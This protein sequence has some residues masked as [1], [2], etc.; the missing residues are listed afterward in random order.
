M[1]AA[2]AGDTISVAAGTYEESLV[3]TKS[4]D[5]VGA[6]SKTTI[7]H[8]DFLVVDAASSDLV[9]S[10]FTIEFQELG[11]YVD[12]EL[13]GSD[14]VFQGTGD[15]SSNGGG[16]FATT[17][18]VDL[19][20]CVFK[21][22]D[23][24]AAYGGLFY[25]YASTVT[26]AN[27]T[28]EGGISQSGGAMYVSTSDVSIS[29]SRFSD[30]E[31]REVDDVPRGAA[32]RQYLGT[33]SLTDVDFT[34]NVVEGGYGAGIAMHGGSAVV[35]RGSFSDGTVTD[36]YGSAIAVFEG[37]LTMIDTVVSGNQEL[38]GLATEDADGALFFFGSTPPTFALDGVT[39]DANYAD[40][41]GSAI[42]VSTGTGTI[43]GCVFTN[44]VSAD[45]GGAIYATGPDPILDRR[46][47][48][49]GK[50]REER[51]CD[52][53]P[54]RSFVEGRRHRDGRRLRV[55]G[56]RGRR[57]RRRHLRA[58]RRHARSPG[59]HVRR[60]RGREGR[61]RGLRVGRRRRR[62]GAQSRGPQR[63]RRGRRV[64][65][66]RQIATFVASSNRFCMNLA[67][68]TTTSD[69][70]AASPLRRRRG[71]HAP[72]V[73]QHLRPQLRRRER[74]RFRAPR[75]R[76]RRGREQHVRERRSEGRR[77]VGLAAF[78]HDCERSPRS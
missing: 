24:G 9:L 25:A 71:R 73:E 20:G 52:P 37:D 60:Q 26:I 28:F 17:A 50:H 18:V 76:G 33:V 68:N 64:S 19:D 42:R 3:V 43:A 7:L 53:L 6:G 78:G 41:D 31:A 30:N 58:R 65:A 66:A 44:N 75:R 32:V 14:L 59:Q 48:L 74:R 38:Y 29:S 36:S 10:G 27:C 77:G 62:T 49:H 61:R 67:S 70:G 5:I 45:N 21:D 39:F 16:L 51:R 56:Q 22:H 46:L 11:V 55:L 12:D 8:D 35:T 1:N 4:L 57:Q 15:G 13:T 40:E 54:R 72:L 47:R 69:G 34:N 23:S 2:T 63:G